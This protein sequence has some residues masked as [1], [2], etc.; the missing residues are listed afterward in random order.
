LNQSAM[1][2]VSNQKYEIRWHQYSK[3]FKH[4]LG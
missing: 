4:C 1:E 3:S 2:S